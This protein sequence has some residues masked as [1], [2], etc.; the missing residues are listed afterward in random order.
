[1]VMTHAVIISRT[2]RH[3]TAVLPRVAPTP[4]IA[5][6][7]AWVDETGIPTSVTATRIA[8]LAVAAQNPW[9]GRILVICFAILST[10]CHPPKQV[11]RPIATADAR[12][13]HAGTA[14]VRRIPE[15]TSRA[16][17]TPTACWPSLAP[18]AVA[19]T[20][21]ASTWRGWKI[22]FIRFWREYRKRCETM[23]SKRKAP[24]I[25]MMG[26]MKMKRTIARSPA[27]RRVPVSIS[28]GMIRAAPQIAPSMA[29]SRISSRNEAVK[30]PRVIAPMTPPIRPLMS[31]STRV[32]TGG[33]MTAPGP[34]TAIPAPISPPTI[35]WLL[36]MGMPARVATNTRMIA[37]PIATTMEK[38]VRPLA[39]TIAVPIVAATAV[40]KRNGPIML[41]IAVYSTALPGERAFVATTVAMEC[42]ASFSPLTKFRA[43]A[44]M[45]PKR[46]RGSM[47]VMNGPSRCR[48]GRARH[49][50][51]SP[52]PLP[53]PRRYP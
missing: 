13:T 7:I 32:L 46:T 51:T 29:P 53:G 40:V 26:E 52:S 45:M 4:M 44:R 28:T 27:T 14:K 38:G 5:P 25:P 6:L 20:R 17:I 34:A 39:L 50:C 10:T 18:W 15:D 47:P 41:P 2:T 48:S 21:L 43:R 19:W 3:C 8:L 30:S 36:E 1:M 33:R 35:A 42:E 16:V 9:Y 49:H 37:E 31:T 24:T 11:P 23:M 22:R 12:M